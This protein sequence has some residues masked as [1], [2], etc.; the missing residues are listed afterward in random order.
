MDYTSDAEY[1]VFAFV[2]NANIF[3][4]GAGE[5]QMDGVC[6]CVLEDVSPGLEVDF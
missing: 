5:G 6:G 3:L 4:F 2:L 1:A